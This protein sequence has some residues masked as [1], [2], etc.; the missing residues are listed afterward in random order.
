MALDGHHRLVDLAGEQERAVVAPRVLVAEARVS[1]PELV[2]TRGAFGPRLHHAGEI[3]Q[4]VGD[5]D[6]DARGAHFAAG[7][8]CPSTTSTA[9]RLAGQFRLDRRDL[10]VDDVVASQRERPTERARLH[11]Q[12]LTR[13]PGEDAVVPVEGDRAGRHG[14]GVPCVDLGDDGRQRAQGGPGCGMR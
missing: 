9:R 11:A 13:M 5:R 6:D 10:R 4:V 3:A 7:L 8:G 1:G 2:G 14:P 12:P